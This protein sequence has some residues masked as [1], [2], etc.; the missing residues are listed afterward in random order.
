MF[1]QLWLFNMNNDGYFGFTAETQIGL[2][3]H[4]AILKNSRNWHNTDHLR[5]KHPNTYINALF[6]VKPLKRADYDVIECHI[7]V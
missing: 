7:G 4:M 3:V 5:H 1:G 2:Q 6:T